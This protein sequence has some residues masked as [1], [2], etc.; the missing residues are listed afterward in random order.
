MEDKTSD[1]F[2]LQECIDFGIY[3][4]NTMM[5]MMM[6][7]DVDDGCFFFFVFFFFFFGGGGC[8][9]FSFKASS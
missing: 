1:R 3:K 2:Y 7:V 5:F 6:T 9:F 8:N 4:V